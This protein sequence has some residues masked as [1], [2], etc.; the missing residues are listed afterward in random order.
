[1]EC[2]SNTG[3]FIMRFIALLI[4]LFLSLGF[5][6]QATE[7]NDLLVKHLYAGTLKDADEALAEFGASGDSERVNE[8]NAARGIVAFVA[9]VERLGQALHR[10]GLETTGGGVLMELPILRMPVEPNL[11]PEPLNYKM[12]RAI[13]QNVFDD[14]AKADTLLAQSLG[15][16]V[17]LTIDLMKVRAD[18]N[19]DGN[20]ADAESLGTI[21][22]L[23]T[24]TADANAPAPDLSFTFDK[25]DVLWLR[26]YIQ[27]I[28]AAAQFGLSID[29]EDSFNKTAHAYFPRAG[30]PMAKDLLTPAQTLGYVDNSVGDLIAMVHL[31]NWNVIE[32]DRLKDVRLRLKLLAQLSRE[33]WK[34]ARAETDNDNEWLP[35]SKQTSKL[36]D[37]PVNDTVIDGWLSVMAEFEMVLEGKKLMPHWRFNKGFNVKRFFEQS[38]HIDAV[39]II[40]G[41][42]AIPF[43]E[44]GPISTS[45]DW[46]NLTR[47]FGGNF[48][49]YAIW[50]N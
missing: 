11:K 14:M 33:S 22:Q 31:L 50:F 17:K 23:L 37:A 26:G 16:E 7:T 44:S 27:F 10:H 49:N 25:A 6:A 24:R 18:L 4:S 43:L 39:L 15:S 3:D 46:E 47:V 29:F 1:M 36:S 48:L 19:S 5:A 45:A 40:G 28:T 32:P 30:L 2:I 9:A 8:T 21:L 35:N 13:L 38:A 20:A 12:Y 34:S 41:V 42:D